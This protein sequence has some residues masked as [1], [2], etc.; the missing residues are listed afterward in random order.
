M[1]A[2]E[3][4]DL[5]TQIETKCVAA[6]Q[7]FDA[8]ITENETQIAILQP[9]LWAIHQ[10]LIADKINIYQ[11]LQQN[12]TELKEAVKE[13]A[14]TRMETVHGTA[15]MAV[16]SKPKTTWDGDKLKGFALAHPE[17]LGCAN[18]STQGSVSFRKL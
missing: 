4:L 10:N 6:M 3:M 12:I 5:I 11:G 7:E 2:E 16:Y 1:T 15:L 13:Q 17:V 8:A 18:I 14:L 9:G